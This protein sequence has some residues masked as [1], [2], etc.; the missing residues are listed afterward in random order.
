VLTKTEKVL[1]HKKMDRKE[2]KRKYMED[3]NKSDRGKAAQDRY[4]SSDKG[5]STRSE[6]GRWSR[7]SSSEQR[8]YLGVAA[9]VLLLL[10]VALFMLSCTHGQKV[11]D[12]TYIKG[13][14]VDLGKPTTVTVTT[15]DN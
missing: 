2:Y 13:Y 7:T 8:N 4:N 1:I 6:Y 14:I 15:H 9:L 12:R 11:H 3:Y 5:R 10:V